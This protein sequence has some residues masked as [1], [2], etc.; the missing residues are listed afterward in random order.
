MAQGQA[1]GTEG[2]GL[3][4][5]RADPRRTPDS[6]CSPRGR[7]LA[8]AERRPRVKGQGSRTKGTTGNQAA[9][10]EPGIRCGKEDLGW[11]HAESLERAD[12]WD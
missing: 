8:G 1:A 6:S 4:P 11:P 12:A 10:E 9:L 5:L 3:G 2:R 7:E